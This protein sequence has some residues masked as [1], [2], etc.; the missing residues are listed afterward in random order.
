MDITIS[1]LEA[2]IAHHYKKYNDE[3]GLF[4]KLIEETGE[5]A[6]VMN[7]RAGRKPSSSDNIDAALANELCDVIHYAVAIAAINNIDLTKAMLEKDE[8]ASVKYHHDINL[9]DFINEKI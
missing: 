2:Y 6:E 4:M 5:V 7:I 3:Q 8:K 1:D 9:K